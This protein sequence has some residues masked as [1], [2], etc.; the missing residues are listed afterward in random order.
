MENLEQ[1]GNQILTAMDDALQRVARGDRAGEESA[2]RR[3][4]GEHGD[5]QRHHPAAQRVA[6]RV[7]DGDVD[8]VHHEHRSQAQEHHE[9]VGEHR[10]PHDAERE[11][12]AD[13][14]HRAAHD[15]ERQR[16]A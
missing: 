6:H 4:A 5:V 16:P 11:L 8:R 3:R 9:R 12:E 15:E 2:D 13:E 14:R 10:Q 7:L 1:Y